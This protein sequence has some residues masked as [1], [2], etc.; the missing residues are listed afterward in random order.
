MTGGKGSKVEETKVDVVPYDPNWPSFFESESARLKTLL[1]RAIGIE[2]FGSTAVPGM[3]AKPTVDILVGTSS[4]SPPPQD[5]IEALAKEGYEFLGEDG[6]RPGRWFF[7]KRGS[8]NFNLSFVPMNSDLWT[9][10]LLLRDYL[11]SDPSAAR[12]YAQVKRA[13]AA[14]SPHSLLSYQDHK[15]EYVQQLLHRAEIG[16]T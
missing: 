7:R 5:E 15:R 6:R 1:P 2:H 8:T 13:A 3:A 12:E 11:R 9:N 4:G 10:N 16:E 14:A